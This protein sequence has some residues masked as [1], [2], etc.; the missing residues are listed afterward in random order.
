MDSLSKYKYIFG[1][2]GEGVHSIRILDVA[3]VDY[4]LTIAGS[5]LLSWAT[6]LPLVLAT[7]LMFIIAILLHWAFGL[8]T[9]AVEYLL[10]IVR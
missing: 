1:K 8:K 9:S 4:A 10:A 3:A 6:K 7:I 5:M 2:P